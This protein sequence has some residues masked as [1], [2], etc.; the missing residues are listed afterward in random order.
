MIVEKNLATEKLQKKI[1][2]ISK[3][4]SFRVKD[5][6]FQLKTVLSDAKKN[7]KTDVD[8]F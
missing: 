4:I 5:L 1:D 8:Y 6:K 7:T 2:L 3:L